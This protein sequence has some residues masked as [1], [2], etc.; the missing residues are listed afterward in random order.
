MQMSQM[1]AST[2]NNNNPYACNP[3]KNKPV[4]SEFVKTAG[5]NFT[6]GGKPWYFGGTNAVYLINGP[7]FPEADIPE[8]F[9]EEI[10][11][12]LLLVRAQGF[13]DTLYREAF[14]H[15]QGKAGDVEA[16]PLGLARPV[17]KRAGEAAQAYLSTRICAWNCPYLRCNL[18]EASNR[19]QLAQAPGRRRELSDRFLRLV[20][21]AVVAIPLQFGRQRR[22]VT[23]LARLLLLLEARLSP[24]IG[25]Q[26]TLA[27]GMPI[28]LDLFGLIETFCS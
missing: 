15:E 26:K 8:F 6:L 21:G 28:S 20:T 7:D 4:S 24:H 18:R 1:D 17:E 11:S 2:N 27:C 16:Q 5:T 10:E 23:I 19:G 14:V 9:A 13:Q 25:P 12:Q 22:V 3:S